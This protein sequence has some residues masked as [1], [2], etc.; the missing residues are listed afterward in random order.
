MRVARRDSVLSH[1]VLVLASL[2]A[3]YPLATIVVRALGGADGWTLANFAQA[4][5]RG[6]FAS[7]LLSSTVVAVS[8]VVLTSVVATLAA[9]AFTFLRVPGAKIILGLLLVGLVL[10][11]EV[12]VYPLYEM[13][14]GF[15][16][17]DTYWA[18]IL[19]Q[20]GLSVPLG[21]FWMN[22]FLG[23]LPMSLVEAAYLDGASRRQVLGSI[24][25][26]L[27]RPAIG[28]MATLVFL[29]TWNEFLL[30]LVLLP[31]NEAVQ[32]APLSLSFFSGAA[33]AT[34]PAVTAAA[35]VL[36]AAP[37]ILFYVL[38]QRRLIS[39]VVDGAVK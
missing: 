24:I 25:A 16:L 15:G 32:T 6:S 28:T 21:V 8:V 23:T 7:A 9:F 22:S 34:D 31:Q 3:V 4:W 1:A 36:V 38:L 37:I 30:A 10:P 19:P 13:L 39:G 29:F 2:I 18:L 11:Y 17:I 5:T 35:A 14:S 26:P 33:R 20:V 27:A 12:T